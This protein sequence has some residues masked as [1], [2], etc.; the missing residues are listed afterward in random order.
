MAIYTRWSHVH[1]ARDYRRTTF[2]TSPSRCPL[3]TC[4]PRHRRE[5]VHYHASLRSNSVECKKLYA[6]RRGR[7][8]RRKRQGEKRERGRND[9]GTTL[10]RAFSRNADIPRDTFET[11]ES[12]LPLDVR[13]YFAV[14]CLSWQWMSV[15]TLSFVRGINWHWKKNIGINT[16]RHRTYRKWLYFQQALINSCYYYINYYAPDYINFI[17]KRGKIFMF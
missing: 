7:G 6:R 16:S 8:E 11:R 3:F 4:T 5:K 12:R 2:L 15:T 1:L 10:R 13:Y 9:A 17:G 14:A